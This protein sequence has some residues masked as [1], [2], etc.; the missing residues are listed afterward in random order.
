MDIHAALR[1]M[2]SAGGPTVSP[3]RP[4]SGGAVGA[5]EVVRPNGASSV[6]TWR[7]PQ[8]GR[9]NA[10]AVAR[11]ADF[12]EVA[13]EVG[14]PAPA[15]EDVVPLADGG[16]VVLREFV[17]GV[18]P[19]LSVDV[20][21][22]LLELTERRRGVLEGTGY[23]KEGTRLYLIDDGPGFCLHGPLRDHD[24]RT[25]RLLDWIEAV[26]RSEADAVVGDDLVHFD[27]HFGN[28]LV[29][30]RDQAR[31]AAILDWDGA[32]SGDV[33][34]DDV[35]LALD[36]VLYNAEPALVQQ[37]ADHLAQA[38]TE[39]ARRAYWAHGLLRLVDWRLRHSPEDGLDWLPRA[40]ALAGV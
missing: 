5:W 38:T 32:S 3:A 22:S 9:D 25:R 40:E 21:T 1:A 23:E 19:H 10:A 31:V 11:T 37:I 28:V 12:V 18:R 6:L 20:I 7:G 34:I 27:Y 16:F 36:L 29:D 30:P 2:A 26:G 17:A 15:Y 39:S 4:L 13:R 14:I 33:G 35:I 8:L 24:R